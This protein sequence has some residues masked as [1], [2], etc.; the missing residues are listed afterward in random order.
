MA[1]SQP[2]PSK[3]SLAPASD[4]KNLASLKRLNS[5]LL[6]INYRESFY[7]DILT[8]PTDAALSRVAFWDGGVSIIGGIRGKWE[9]P[10]PSSGN[11]NGGK[12]YLM[13]ICV[14]SPF[15]RLGVATALLADVIETAKQWGVKE[16]YAH[17]WV[18]NHE[19]QGWYERRGFT[20]DEDVVEGYYRKL[21]PSGA[22][23]VRLK[24]NAPEYE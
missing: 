13:T 8:N 23:I 21:R 18:E 5:L 15:R 7:K 11:K 17:V 4:T 16:I 24:I 19:A 14:L 22:K 3:L 2:Q 12:I 1:N 10:S 6:P 9:P 20:I